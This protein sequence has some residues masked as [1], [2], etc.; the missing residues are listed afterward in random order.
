MDGI[1]HICLPGQMFLHS[2]GATQTQTRAAS[3]FSL[4]PVALVRQIYYHWMFPGGPPRYRKGHM[5]YR[6]PRLSH[7]FYGVIYAGRRGEGRRGAVRLLHA[8]MGTSGRE[9]TEETEEER[10]AVSAG[11]SCP[12]LMPCKL[13]PGGGG[14]GGLLDNVVAVVLEAVSLAVANG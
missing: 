12:L 6:A 14:G 3:T 8:G 5:S 9:R 11:V 10:L 7:R 2:A 1:N 4:H 13:P